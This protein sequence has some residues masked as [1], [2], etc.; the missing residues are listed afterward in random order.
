MPVYWLARSNPVM[1]CPAVKILACRLI[2]SSALAARWVWQ[3]A[4]KG[5]EVYGHALGALVSVWNPP[6]IFYPPPAIP[7]RTT[8]GSRDPAV[9]PYG[10]V[11]AAF[12]GVLMASKSGRSLTGIKCRRITNEI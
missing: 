6:P 3:F 8:A 7:P 4:C 12:E 2:D 5:N 9:S 1:N 10:N 11:A